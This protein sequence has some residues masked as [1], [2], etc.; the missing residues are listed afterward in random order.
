MPRVR[1]R[2]TNFGV[3]PRDISPLLK[4]FRAA[5]GRGDLTNTPELMRKYRI[6]QFSQPFDGID[7]ITHVD[8]VFTSILYFWATDRANE[9]HLSSIVPLSTLASM[10][11]LLST[12]DMGH[13]AEDFP[14]ARSMHRKIIMHVGPTNSGKTHNALRALAAARVGVYA[15]PLRL[16][17]HEIWERLNKGQIVP[18]GVD[19]AAETLAEA[20]DRTAFDVPG[21]SKEKVAVRK[22]GN[23]KYARLCN[24]LTGED[25]KIVHDSAPLTSATVEMLSTITVYDVAVVDEIQ[26]IGDPERGGAWTN[27]VLGL[28]AKELHLCGEET[29]VPIIEALA[30]ETGDE[31]IV[32]RY[33]RLTPLQVE[34]RS[35]KGYLGNIRPGDCLVTFSRNG[36][37]ALKKRVEEKTHYKCAVVYGAL[38][39]EVRSEQAALFNDPESGYAVLIGS[40]AI[41]MGL[42]LCVLRPSHWPGV[43]HMLCLSQQDQ[44][45]CV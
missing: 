38:P 3:P 7:K 15:G 41:G 25:Q 27:A 9:L 44:T 36:I 28:R 10:R 34:H 26:M 18:L 37:F 6:E 45:H 4:T 14:Y 42:N 39:P 31:V 12:L 24:L 13:P 17:A 1:V 40:D 2:L 11:A 32:N 35:L 29:A 16:L 21:G 22:E 20:D 8:R 23:P 43:A 30:R 33:Q 19:L 5:A